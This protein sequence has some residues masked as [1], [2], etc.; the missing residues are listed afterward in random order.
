MLSIQCKSKIAAAMAGAVAIAGAA[1]ASAGMSAGRLFPDFSR[2]RLF[3]KN[4]KKKRAAGVIV[5]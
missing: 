4:A 5:A 3:C 1:P 2:I